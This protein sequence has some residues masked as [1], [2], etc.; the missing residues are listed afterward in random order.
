MQAL[1]CPL[2]LALLTSPGSS[3]QG[4]EYHPLRHING[5]LGNLSWAIGFFTGIEL[6]V[7]EFTVPKG[8]GKKQK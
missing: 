4:I 7:T 1:H 8:G 6:I 3:E 5:G 2:W